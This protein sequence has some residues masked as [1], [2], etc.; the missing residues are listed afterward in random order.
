MTTYKSK[1]K[2]S[3][4]RLERETYLSN[5]ENHIVAVKSSKCTK[6]V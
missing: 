3:T 4:G 5:T 1:L 2:I 6:K